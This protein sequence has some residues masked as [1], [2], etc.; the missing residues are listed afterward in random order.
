MTVAEA[1]PEDKFETL[2][3]YLR[4]NRGFD[5]SGYKRPSL[6][7]RVNRRMQTVNISTFEDYLDFLEVHPEEFAHLF[8]TILINVT[9]FFRDPDAWTYLQTEII[10]R[11][12]AAKK[13]RGPI[14]ILSAGCASGEETYSLAIAFA[15][16]LGEEKFGERVKIYAS[17]VDDEA[18]AIARQGSYSAQA[19]EPLTPEQR[20][21]FFERSNSRLVFR[22]DLRRSIIFGRHDLLHDAPISRLDLLVCRNTLMYF[23]AETQ[24]HILTGFHFALNNGE[25]FLFLGRAELLFTHAD[26]FSP[27]DLKQRVFSTTPQ[28]NAGERWSSS[29][30]LNNSEGINHATRHFRLREVALDVSPLARIVLNVNSQIAV[31]SKKAREIFGLTSLDVGRPLKD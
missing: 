3:E 22:S 4:E 19:V 11:I 31:I 27:L 29:A 8:D 9:A 7:R 15:E 13:D 25:A 18:L 14:R 17:D 30:P 1:S 23:N 12:L 2:L 28:A 5:F 10:P 24:G 26:L 20:E 6:M 21:R 16:A